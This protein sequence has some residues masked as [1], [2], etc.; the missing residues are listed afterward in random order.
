VQIDLSGEPLDSQG[1]FDIIIHKVN[2]EIIT[3]SSETGAAR[4]LRALEMYIASHPRTPIIDPLYGVRV[5][6]DRLQLYRFLEGM[7]LS[8]PPH[9]CIKPLR[10]A[11]LHS[12]DNPRAACIEAG[13]TYPIVCKTVVACSIGTSH[14]MAVAMNE[15]GLLNCGLEL[16]VIAQ[17][18]VNHRGVIHKIYVAGETW[19]AQRRQS[20]RAMSESTDGHDLYKFNSQ[21]PPLD[22]FPPIPSE[23]GSG[24]VSPGPSS[25]AVC[26]IVD[27]VKADLG[28]SLF[29][30]DI[31]VD[32]DSGSCFVIDVNYFPAYEGVKNRNELLLGHLQRQLNPT[33]HPVTLEHIPGS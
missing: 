17:Q 32:I 3:E 4:R 20:L 28:L 12:F 15:R 18:Y 31:L 7:S 19:I 24:Q 6:C 8:A 14:D 21:H 5:V 26:Y 22:L 25:G 13:L 33:N 16:P 11:L 29:G 23:S 9:L 2:L 10:F 27:R 1:E 30:L